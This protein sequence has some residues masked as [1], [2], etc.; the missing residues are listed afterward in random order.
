M[1][2]PWRSN[3]GEQDEIH[4]LNN[5]DGVYVQDDWKMLNNLSVN[6]G[7]RWDYDSEFRTKKNFGPRLGV[8]WAVTPKTVVRANFGVYYDQFRLGLVKNIPAF[9][10]TDQRTG[11]LFVFPRLLYGSPSYVSSIALLSG[12]PG[13]CFQNLTTGNLTDAQVAA[14]GADGICPFTGAPFIG[15]DRLNR[16]VAAGRQPI[17]ANTVVTSAN[18]QAL[19]G[20]NSTAIC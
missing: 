14:A 6:L 3:S 19:T 2:Q 5:Y 12:L 16:V 11:Q 17:P 1:L 8:A 10:G 18:V 20:L 15:V 13:G 7:I 9:G 4:L